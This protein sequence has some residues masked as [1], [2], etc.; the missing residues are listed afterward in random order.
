ML[1]DGIT[2]AEGAKASNLSVA[3]GT[4]FP[5]SPDEGELF[6]KEGLGLHV[7]QNGE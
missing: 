1:L 3:S 2:L 4:S 6:V 5:S 7:Y